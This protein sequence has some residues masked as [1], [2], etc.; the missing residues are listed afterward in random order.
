M[1]IYV[2]YEII[3]VIIH[4]MNITY[5]KSKEILLEILKL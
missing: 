3:Y 1:V 4:V 5:P 2:I